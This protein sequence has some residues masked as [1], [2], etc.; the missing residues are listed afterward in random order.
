[1]GCSPGDR[2]ESDMTEGACTHS[3]VY[4]IPYDYAYLLKVLRGTHTPLGMFLL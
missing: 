4:S 2:K 3:I 1:M